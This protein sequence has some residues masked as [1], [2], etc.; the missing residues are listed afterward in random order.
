MD[1]WYF[2]LSVYFVTAAADIGRVHTFNIQQDE[3]VRL[4]CIV[5]SKQDAEEAMWMR[6]RPPHNPDILTYRDSVVYTPDRIELEQRRLSSIDDE[7]RYICSKRRAI[8]AEYDLFIIIPPQFIDDDNFSQQRAIIEG[9]TLHLSC[10]AYGR[11]Q[12][13]ITWFYRAQDDKRIILGDGV[14]CLDRMCELHLPN[15][16]RDN[17]DTV[18][19][20]ADNQKSSRIS[21]VFTID[22]IYPPKITTFVRTIGGPKSTDVFLECLSLAN[23]PPV[24]TWLDNDRREIHSNH[25]YTVRQVNQSSVLSFST[26]EI[27]PSQVIYHCRSHN[28]LGSMEKFINISYLIESTSESTPTQVSTTSTTMK[29]TRARPR[30]ITTATV[31][32]TTTL[33][34]VSVTNI[35]SSSCVSCYSTRFFLVFILCNFFKNTIYCTV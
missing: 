24:I 4:E 10:S 29:S 20:V 3:R 33:A 19:C 2:F 12:P 21:K 14:G 23:P 6:I 9:S 7:G 34:V 35:P 1:W 13:S 8:F 5:T 31:A 15:Y 17:P 18:E 26:L 28:S 32:T 25:L 22:V 27:D 30:T 16:T 11:P